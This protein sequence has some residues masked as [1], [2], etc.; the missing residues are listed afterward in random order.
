MLTD[1]VFRT[2]I[3]ISLLAHAA[4]IAPHAFFPQDKDKVVERSRPVE[5]NYIVISRPELADNAEI[6]KE[7]SS[8]SPK[9]EPQ[10]QEETI[11]DPEE[12]AKLRLSDMKDAQYVP[13]ETRR[14]NVQEQAFLTYCNI[15][16]EK[17]RSRIRVD[18]EE[19]A[20]S[21]IFMLDRRGYLQRVDPASSGDSP[22]LKRRA[23][24]GLHLAQPFPPF[25]EKMGPNPITF[26]LTVKFTKSP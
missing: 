2:A 14:D 13:D 1:P 6:Y 10:E 4:F 15:I 8:S 7:S 20:V 17:I 19:G 22:E 11:F 25:P 3:A 16:R 18:E 26:S 24:R 12:S 9:N 21:L 5:L 23:L